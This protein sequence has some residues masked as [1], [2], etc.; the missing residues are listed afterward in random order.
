MMGENEEQKEQGVG[1][2]TGKQTT[3]KERAGKT[4]GW[5]KDSRTGVPDTA[6]CHAVISF[7]TARKWL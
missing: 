1:R 3:E 2:V 5:K 6:Q 7:D 4:G